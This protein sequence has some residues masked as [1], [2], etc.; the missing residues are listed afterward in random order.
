M[1]YTQ[2]ATTSALL[3]TVRGNNTLVNDL[4][5]RGFY[6][7][8]VDEFNARDRR[9]KVNFSKV[10]SEEQ[11]LIATR[12]YPEFQI[13]FYNTQNAVHSFA[14][15][16]RSLEL[17]YLMRQIPYGSLTN[18]IGGNFASHLFKGRAYVHC[19]MPNFDVRD[20]MR[21]EGQ[22]NSIE[23][24]LSRV[25]RGNKVVPNFQK[26]AFDRYAETPDE[27][28]CPSPFQTGTPQQGENPGG[29]FVIALHSIYDIPAD[30]FGGALLRK[31]VH[32]CYPPFPFS[33]N[34]LLENSPVNLDEIN[35]GFSRDGDKRT[36]SFASGSPL[37]Y[38]HSYFNI[39]KYVCK[40]YFPASNREVYKKEFLV[41]RVNTGF[42]KFSRINTFFL[43]KGV[44]HKGVKREQFYSAMEDAWH[45]KK[46]LAMCNSERILLEDSS[47]VNYWFPKMRDMVIVPLFDISLDTSKR[48]RKEVLVSK[49][50]VFTVLNH[51]RTYQ[52]K[53]L[54]YSNVLS[55]VESIRSRV[56]I[57]GVT[58]RSE[59]DVDKSLLQS[60]SMTFFLHTKLAVLK[61]ELLISKFSLGP[62]SVSQHVWDEISLAFGNAFPSIKERLLNRKL[63]KVSGDALE[64]RVPDLYVTFHDRLV[65]EYKTSVDMP[66]LDIRKR[67]EETEV[68]YNALS[69]LSVL[70]ESDKFD[71]DVFSRMCQTLEV[72]PMTAAKVIV[73][74]MSNES[75]LTLTFEQPTE[76]NVALALKDSEKASE[77]ALVVTSRDVE[78]PSMKGS[79]AR[80]ELQ[81]AGLSGDQPES[82]Y[83]RNEEIESL[84]QFHM[85]TASSLIRKQMSSIV[86]T[87]PTKVQQM[88]NFIDSLVA[89]LS[90]AVSNLVK[91]LKDTAA[92]DLETRQKFGV[93]DVATKRW[94]IKPLPKNPAWGVFETYARKY[95]VAFLEYDEHGGETCN[96]GK[97]GAGSSESMVYSD[98]ANL[99]TLRRL[100]RDGGPHVSSAK[101]VLVDG[102]PGCGKTKEIL[103]KLN[104]EEDLILV[105]GK[106]AAEMIKRRAN[107]S[108]II[109]ATRDNVRTVDSF[110]MNYGKGT[111]CQFKRL[112]IDEGL[113]L[114]T[115][116]V[117]FLVSMSLCEI[118]YV[119]GDTQQI[120]YINRVSGFPY[121]AHFAKIEV[122]EVETR[123]TTLRCPADITHYLN[124]RYEGYVM[125]TSSVK[126][127]VSQEMVSGAAMINPVSRP[128]NGKVLTF[129]QSDKE[130]LLSRG[131]TDVHTVHEVQ[132]ETYA[133]VSLV[134]LTPT[135]ISIIAGDSPHVLVALSR[136]TQ[137][138]K[139]YTVVMDPLVSIIRDLEKLSS[140]LLDMY[141]VDAGTQ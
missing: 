45:Y 106:Q 102:V 32:V 107:A 51:I 57:N 118:A 19:C 88:K 73:A 70:K 115:G 122:D 29:G 119:Y 58:A 27:V 48:T 16:L 63:I 17:E 127:S 94:L 92:I 69:E 25:E 97:R 126:K 72:D 98:M 71:V 55:F 120:P 140:Y 50:F 131:Y 28:V 26:E 20:I 82:S 103:S 111:R 114:H 110:I 4:A 75:G 6:D 138:L 46:T 90:A 30:E 39:L 60:L 41:T 12:A 124:R 96:S 91:I 104:F 49:D 15:G 83:T 80:G 108:G 62:K 139:Y 7:T 79:M 129:T 61:D 78:E 22:K 9:P 89:S 59:W 123:R 31:N 76:A 128:L 21:P 34:L 52:A 53:E 66:V 18:D 35:G 101:V 109:Q 87:G 23:L 37:N 105:R 3:D 10:I 68:M 99:K 135:P 93:L 86:Y 36:F 2:T 84:E 65:A 24:Y 64:I 1:A 47:S 81:L 42:C 11:T 136:H 54:T 44:A 40:T 56:I 130:A 113:M 132:G 14:G 77:G 95:P 117:N 33:E 43:Y 74:V 112:F 67:M 100:L 137:T 5:K 38:C 85:A 13:P 141:K 116:C 133:D 125:C 8:A 121:P 134:R